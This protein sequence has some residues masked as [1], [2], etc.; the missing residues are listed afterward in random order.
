M[1]L[2]VVRRAFVAGLVSRRLTESPEALEEVGVALLQR[3]Y[4]SLLARNDLVEFV[5]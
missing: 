4:G 2:S 5:Q 3:G 1:R